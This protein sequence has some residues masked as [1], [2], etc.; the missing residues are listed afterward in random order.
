VKISIEQLKNG[1][2]ITVSDNGIGRVAA[3]EMDTRG[4]GLGLKNITDLVDAMNRGNSEK[5]TVTL[6]DLYA[7]EKP[8]G[9]EVRIF[10]PQPYNFDLSV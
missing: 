8:S 5:I 2:G 3:A 9:T 4:G 10:L 7:D 6:S 1:L